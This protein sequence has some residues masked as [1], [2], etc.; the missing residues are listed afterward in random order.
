MCFG[1]SRSPRDVVGLICVR[2][3]FVVIPYPFEFLFARPHG[4]STIPPRAPFLLPLT[5]LPLRFHDLR[6]KEL[7]RILTARG[8]L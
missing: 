3:L 6:N 1:A 5:K 4:L 2:R 7:V 8:A